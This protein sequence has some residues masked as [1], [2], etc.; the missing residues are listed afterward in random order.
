MCTLSHTFLPAL[1]LCRFMSARASLSF[2]SLASTKIWLKW[3]ACSTWSLQPPQSKEPLE[4][5]DEPFLVGSQEQLSRSP[6][7]QAR[8][9]VYT[10]PAEEMAYT[11]ATS[12]LPRSRQ[13]WWGKVC[14]FVPKTCICVE[15]RSSGN[16]SDLKIDSM[17]LHWLMGPGYCFYCFGSQINK[18]KNQIVFFL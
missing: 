4:S 18:K 13:L 5:C 8:A 16:S 2:L 15:V 12:W 14:Y 17:S 1:L 11:K 7:L 10:T 6:W 9:K 3:M